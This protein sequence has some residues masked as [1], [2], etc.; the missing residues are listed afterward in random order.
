M[1]D[2]S[3]QTPGRRRR[4]VKAFHSELLSYCCVMEL[5]KEEV[6]TPMYVVCSDQIRAGTVFADG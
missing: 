4:Q 6:L 5:S 2:L 1:V 3:V